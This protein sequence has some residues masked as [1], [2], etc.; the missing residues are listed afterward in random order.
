MWVPMLGRIGNHPQAGCPGI[1]YLLETIHWLTLD[2][3]VST[4]SLPGQNTLFL[5]HGI[6]RRKRKQLNYRQ[7]TTKN[8]G[9][10]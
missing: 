10:K 6:Q 8:E 2:L 9:H 3:T 7:R 1:L 4:W 5:W